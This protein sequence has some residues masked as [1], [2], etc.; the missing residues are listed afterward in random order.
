MSRPFLGG[1]V[2]LSREDDQ[3]VHV[4]QISGK[5]E[6]PPSL[7]HV[8]GTR[9]EIVI[10]AKGQGTTSSCEPFGAMIYSQEEDMTVFP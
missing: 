8:Y 4:Q 2:H 6:E 5:H 1:V 9:I 10:V 3:L 7:Q